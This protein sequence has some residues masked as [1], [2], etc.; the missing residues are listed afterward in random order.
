MSIAKSPGQYFIPYHAVYR[1]D[2]GDS[3]I[4][5]VFDVSAHGPRGSSLNQYLHPGPK[6][7][8]DIIVVLTPFRIHKF[9]FTAD[10]CKMYVIVGFISGVARPSDYLC[11]T[12]EVSRT[13][14]TETLLKFVSSHNIS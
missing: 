2:D 6:L 12:I 8:Q 14:T 13:T 7:Q 4:R 9:A 1:P 5:V 10:I 11:P 3:K